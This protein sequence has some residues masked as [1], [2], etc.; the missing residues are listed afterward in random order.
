MKEM[1]YVILIWIRIRNFPPKL[2][3][4]FQPKFEGTPFLNQFFVVCFIE[5]APKNSERIQNLQ[6]KQFITFSRRM[7]V[8]LKREIMHIICHYTVS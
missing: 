2:S 1:L 5:K 4:L 6:Q 8:M 7:E 3:G